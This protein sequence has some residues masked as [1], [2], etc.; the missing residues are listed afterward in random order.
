MFTAEVYRE[1]ADHCRRLARDLD[2]QSRKS[3]ENLAREYDDGAMLA[4]LTAKA[5][6]PLPTTQSQL[7]IVD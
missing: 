6:L 1:K 4:E 2:A 5:E 3:L 7:E